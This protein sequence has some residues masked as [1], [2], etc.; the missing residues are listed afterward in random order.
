MFPEYIKGGT[1]ATKSIPGC[2]RASFCFHRT[3]HNGK[4]VDDVFDIFYVL[5]YIARSRFVAADQFVEVNQ[6]V[7]VGQNGTH[8]MNDAV[9]FGTAVFAEITFFLGALEKDVHHFVALGLVGFKE[10][11]LIGPN[12]SA[13]FQH[14]L[15]MPTHERFQTFADHNAHLDWELIKNIFVIVQDFQDVEGG[16]GR[17][18]HFA[19][20]DEH[21]FILVFILFVEQPLSVKY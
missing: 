7:F 11:D 17:L 12:A 15:L 5:G 6:I 20:D 9:A 10:I 13:E 14:D 3:S 21:L 4:S 2:L 8:Q 19:V 16:A 18:D 1:Q